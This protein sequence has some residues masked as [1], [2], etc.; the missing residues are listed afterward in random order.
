MKAWP[1]VCHAASLQNIQWFSEFRDLVKGRQILSE[2]VA[3]LIIGQATSIGPALATEMKKYG[4]QSKYRSS[5]SVRRP[6]R[7]R[8]QVWLSLMMIVHP[9]PQSDLAASG[10]RS[11]IR[12]ASF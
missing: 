7:V 8:T 3:A 9:F 6:H 10:I 12:Q 11:A 1:F 4:L 2:I 5:S